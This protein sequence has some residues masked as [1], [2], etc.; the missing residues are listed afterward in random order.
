MCSNPLILFTNTGST[1]VTSM[2]IDYWLNDSPD[3]ETFQWSGNL[4]FMDTITISLPVGLLWSHG[5]TPVNNIF[6]AE[7]KTVNGV[8]DQ[9]AFNNKYNSAVVIPE[10]LPENITVDFKT[11]NNPFES[12]YQLVDYSGSDISA[13]TPLVAPNTLY[14]DDYILNGCYTLKVQ[15]SGEDGLSFWNNTAQGSGLVRIKN[16]AGTVIKSFNMDFGSGFEYSFSTIPSDF[17]GI[18]Q[19][20]FATGIKIFPNPAH[21]KFQVTGK[22]LEGSVIKIV[23]LLGRELVVPVSSDKS[24]LV[25]DVSSLKPGVYMVSIT[26]GSQTAIKKIVVN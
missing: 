2:D 6:H 18:K 10:V 14:S 21:D 17:V 12:S 24:G 15:D 20:S 4:A 11:N 23:D 9:Y 25:F 19:Q 3:K 16:S 5:L 7:I 1:P 22:N 8:A 13:Q 26:S